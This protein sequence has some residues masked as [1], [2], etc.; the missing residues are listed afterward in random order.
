MV[1]QPC[2]NIKINYNNQK[3]YYNRILSLKRKNRCALELK[4]QWHYYKYYKKKLKWN[5]MQLL[6]TS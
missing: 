1:C 2:I 5:M 3:Q 4:F 6:N